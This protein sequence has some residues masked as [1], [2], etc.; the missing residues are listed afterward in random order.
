MTR[1]DPTIVYVHGNGNKLAKD[2]LKAKWDEALFGR[3]MGETTR[4]AYYADLH[5][6][7]P[8]PLEESVTFDQ[9]ALESLGA[10]DPED[11]EVFRADLR[12]D[13]EDEFGE[14]DPGMISLMDRLVDAEPVVADREP[15]QDSGLEALPTRWLRTLALRRLTKRFARDVYRYF[16]KGADTGMK[17]RVQE[18]LDDLEGP[19]VVLGHSLGSIVA[20]DV[21]N[22]LPEGSKDVRLYLTV[23]SPL[24]IKEV[25]DHLSQP[26]RVPPDVDTWTN[27]SD[28]RDIVALDATLRGDFTPAEKV[29]DYAVDNWTNNNHSIQGYL[30]KPEALQAIEE[31]I[32][33][34][35]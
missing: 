34:V 22:E 12:T 4:M 28:R 29:T 7:Q 30:D 15:P 32:G 23:G 27:L 18:Q 8:L 5:Y 21:L 14:L 10:N 13:M 35:G 25:Q 20:Y 24:G 31:A 2:E 6:P 3:D 33:P 17:A 16:F 9:I 19:I 26:Q 11:I 1:T